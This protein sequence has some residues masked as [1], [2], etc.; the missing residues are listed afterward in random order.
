MNSP[1]DGKIVAV[2][3]D[4][5]DHFRGAAF[6][7]LYLNIGECFLKL[8]YS[9]QEGIGP[10]FWCCLFSGCAGKPIRVHGSSS[11]SS[12]SPKIFSVIV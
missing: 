12:I 6:V 2:V 10:G 5:L 8:G 3:Q 4:A 11:A 1:H 9:G 7:D